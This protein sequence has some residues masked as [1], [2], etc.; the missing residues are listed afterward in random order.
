MDEIASKTVEIISMPTTELSDWD[1]MIHV[2]TLSQKEIMLPFAALLG[3]DDRV[4]E[5]M[6]SPDVDDSRYSS[7]S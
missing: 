2:R 4:R 3:D 6:T 5:T 7:S 1:G